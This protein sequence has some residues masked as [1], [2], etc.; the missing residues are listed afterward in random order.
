MHRPLVPWSDYP[1]SAHLLVLGLP[2]HPRSVWLTVPRAVSAIAAMSEQSAHAISPTSQHVLT[3][4]LTLQHSLHSPRLSEAGNNGLKQVCGHHGPSTLTLV[5]HI[6]YES[7]EH[8][9]ECDDAHADHEGCRAGWLTLMMSVSLRSTSCR[10]RSSPAPDIRGVLLW[11][12]G[13]GDEGPGVC[14]PL[15]PC[16]CA[17]WAG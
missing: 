7:R 12:G 4:A 2:V 14:L 10:S 16:C 13:V 11:G 3:Q 1:I 17:G 15:P 6:T 5:L 9:C 8:S